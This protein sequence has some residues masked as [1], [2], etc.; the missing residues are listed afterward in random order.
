MKFLWRSF[1]ERIFSKKLRVE[2]I[3]C[4]LMVSCLLFGVSS[5]LA[6]NRAWGQGGADDL[7]GRVITGVQV[8]GNSR[9]L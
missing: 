3:G 5:Q 2:S 9:I 4:V 1:A 6:G 8:V 7:E